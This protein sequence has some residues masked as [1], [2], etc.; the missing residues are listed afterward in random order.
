MYNYWIGAAAFAGTVLSVAVSQIV[1][2]K[3]GRGAYILQILDI[4]L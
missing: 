4:C 3:T 1:R 2:W